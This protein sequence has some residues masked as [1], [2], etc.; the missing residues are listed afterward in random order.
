MNPFL[1]AVLLT[2][3]ADPS[4]PVSPS[5]AAT[6]TARTI[7]SAPWYSDGFVSTGR[8]HGVTEP[9]HFATISA[10][11][12]TTL[13]KLSVTEGQQVEQGRVMD[14]RVS[15]ASV[16]AARITADR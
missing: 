7:A 12:E 16:R 4:S 10:P 3:V 14:N 1:V 13:M 9:I 5:D 11:V 8:I 6:S 15:A 2:L